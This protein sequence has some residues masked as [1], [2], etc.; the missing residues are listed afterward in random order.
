MIWVRYYPW[1]K[2]LIRV[3]VLLG[4]IAACFAPSV[5]ASWTATAHG[6]TLHEGFVNP[7]VVDGKD[8]GQDLYVSFTSM[9]LG[10][11]AAALGFY[12]LIGF[13][14]SAVCDVWVALSVGDDGLPR[15]RVSNRFFWLAVVGTIALVQGGIYLNTALEMQSLRDS[16]RT[17]EQ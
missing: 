9:W 3:G 11:I 2:H 16:F 13:A 14:V 8:I 12:I 4:I 7:C 1:A 6:C 15:R 5:M 10:A 17:T